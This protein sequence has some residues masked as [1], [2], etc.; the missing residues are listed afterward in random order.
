MLEYSHMG[1]QSKLSRNKRTEI[2]RRNIANQPARTEANR[3]RKQAKHLRKYPN[4][5]PV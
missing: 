1:A 3:K 5:K 4:Y 2:Q